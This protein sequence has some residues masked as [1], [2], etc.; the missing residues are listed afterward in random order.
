M[1]TASAQANCSIACAAMTTVRP[2]VA[3]SISAL[4]SARRALS[5]FA[6]GSSRS[7]VGAVRTSTRASATRCRWPPLSVRPR[8][9]THVSRPDGM[10]S[11]NVAPAA[12]SAARTS[13]PD[14]RGS[15]RVTLSAIVPENRCGCW[16]S[17]TASPPSVA[18]SPAS[19]RRWP[20]TR[21][22]T[23]VFP[24]PLGPHSTTRCPRATSKLRSR[25]P[26]LR[27]GCVK[28]TC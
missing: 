25:I 10:E 21:A 19:G 8:S 14:Q 22:R 7:S 13:S 27:P 12:A 28:V 1:I 2:R 11:T 3:R 23:V 20:S 17:Q 24:A 15:P 26:V 9:P 5:R 18:T 6:S 16:G 4:T